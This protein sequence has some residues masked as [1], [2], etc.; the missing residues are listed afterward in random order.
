MLFPSEANRF[1]NKLKKREQQLGAALGRA[2]ANGLPEPL[3]DLYRSTVAAH[4]AVQHE[5]LRLLDVVNASF[6]SDG[7]GAIDPQ[8]VA[9]I[10]HRATA[11][12]REIEAFIDTSPRVEQGAARVRFEELARRWIE[13]EAERLALVQGLGV[14]GGIA[15][16]MQTLYEDLKRKVLDF[17]APARRREATAQTARS[18]A[19]TAIDVA[20]GAVTAG[21]D[22]VSAGA[23]ALIGFS[24]ALDRYFDGQMVEDEDAQ[25]H[26]LWL[27]G[28]R[29]AAV[30]WVERTRRFLEFV[31]GTLP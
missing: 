25:A 10:E 17:D 14:R 28:Y 22:V 24:D 8:A 21:A 9:G 2:Q 3:V 27:A 29:K 20:T 11:L 18:G 1:L 30:E 26:Y 12:E 19:D 5:L 6:Y 31:P 16:V 4:E 7:P 13:L 23:G 15:K